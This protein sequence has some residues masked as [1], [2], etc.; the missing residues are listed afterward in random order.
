V[1]FRV[2]ASEPGQARLA[3]V[4]GRKLML[5][6]V[7]F[8]VGYGIGGLLAPTTMAKLRLAPDL[9]ERP[10]ARLFVRGFS[11]HQIGVAALGLASLRWRGLERAAG[12]AAVAIDAAD[13]VSA[14]AEAAERGRLE[15]DLAGGLIFS[16]AGL[17]TASA[18][19]S[20]S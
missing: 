19:V 1:G 14:T 8:R 10:D 7:V 6:N 3:V 9:A 11:A 4:S 17:V 18:A 15:A 20:L 2:I 12:L 16:A 13:I 5:T